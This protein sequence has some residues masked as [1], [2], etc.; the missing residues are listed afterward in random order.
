MSRQPST[1]R[2]S[3]DEIESIVTHADAGLDPAHSIAPPVYQTSTYRIPEGTDLG[4]VADTPRHP[5]FY[6]RHG[7]PTH[8]RVE[9]ILA[10]LEG[11]QAALAMSS[12][13]AAVT[14]TVMTL[15]SAGDHIVAQQGLYI[16]SQ[17]LLRN[18]LPRFGVEATI[19]DQRDAEA[20]RAAMRPNTRLFM[21]E[22]PC[23]P[24]LT[25]TDL[26]RVAAIARARG[27]Q[28]LVDNTFATPVNQRP[29]RHGIDIVVHSATKYLGGHSDLSAGVVAGRAEL[30]ARIWKSHL[31]L[32]G[33]LGPFE[34][35]LLLRGLRTLPLR[36]RHVNQTAQAVAEFLAAHP[37]VT[38]VYY[39]GLK[40]HPQHELARRLMS[41]FGGVI[42]FEVRGGYTVAHEAIRRLQVITHAVSFGGTESLIVHPAEMWH[43]VFTDEQLREGGV[44]PSLVRLGIGLENAADLIADLAQA[45]EGA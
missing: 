7:H 32:G 6:T 40:S 26:D 29:L 12:G 38:T 30:I 35:W 20:F 19:V 2:S 25:I 15:V 33:V 14:A 24:L 11:A 4:A 39:P 42:T 5:G 37:R 28:T 3:F 16:G 1:R 34:S 27:I 45:L 10:R 44:S 43:G 18:V 41:G 23:N 21:M 17:N 9:T 31:V 13:V 22:T 36:M 8:S